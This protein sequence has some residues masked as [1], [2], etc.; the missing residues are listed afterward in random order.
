MLSKCEFW[1]L[2]VDTPINAC[3]LDLSPKIGINLSKNRKIN[4]RFNVEIRK[5]R[6]IKGN[7]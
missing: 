3:E 4:K 2:F 5:F 1:P 6:N 7:K